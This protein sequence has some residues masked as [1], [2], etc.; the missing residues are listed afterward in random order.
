FDK[1]FR[2][3]KSIDRNPLLFEAVGIYAIALTDTMDKEKGFV[4][5]FFP[6]NMVGKKGKSITVL[7][8]AGKIEV[9]GKVYDAFS[10]GEYIESGSAIEV[11]GEDTTSL[12]VK[13]D[14]A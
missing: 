5:T 10:R 11:I 3:S 6:Q 8:P 9:E 2:Y 4:G 7:R 13:K 1:P 14:L 12:L